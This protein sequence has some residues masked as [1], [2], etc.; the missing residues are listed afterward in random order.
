MVEEFHKLPEIDQV[1]IRA[2]G[3][4]GKLAHRHGESF[5]LTTRAM[6]TLADRE[7]LQSIIDAKQQAVIISYA[8][9]SNPCEDPPHSFFL[10]SN[11]WM[12]V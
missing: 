12:A 2:L 5:G 3:E 4:A 10:K 6:A 8:E 7:R 9:S 11:K 1:Q